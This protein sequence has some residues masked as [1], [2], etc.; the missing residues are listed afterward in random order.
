MTNINRGGLAGLGSLF[1]FLA[2][3]V[4]AADEPVT[5]LE[6]IRVSTTATEFL[7]IDNIH[8]VNTKR[9]I[10]SNGSGSLDQSLGRDYPVQVLTNGSPGTVTFF[11]G[12]GVRSE[13]TNVQTLGVSLNPAYGGGFDFSTM[14]LFMWSSYRYQV[15]QTSA[16]FDPRSSS[17]VVSLTPWTAEE[18]NKKPSDLS[19]QPFGM[20]SSLGQQQI[21]LRGTNASRTAA[22]AIGQSLGLSQ[23]QSGTLSFK[24]NLGVADSIRFH[25]IATDLLS[26]VPGTTVSPTPL[27][28]QRSSRLLPIINWDH[29][30]ELIIS[31]LTFYTDLTNLNYRSPEGGIETFDQARVY[32]ANYA[33]GFS[34]WKFGLLGK[35]LVYKTYIATPEEDLGQVQIIKTI[36]IG[37]KFLIEPLMRATTITGYGLLPEAAL[38]FRYELSQVFK[39]FSR[40]GVTRRFP[41]LSDRFYTLPNGQSQANAGLEPETDYSFTLGVDTDVAGRMNNLLQLTYQYSENTHQFL[42]I[43][44]GSLTYS[45]QN[46]GIGQM[47]S[48]FHIVRV[49]LMP[50]FEMTKT[51]SI[52]LSRL[53]LTRGKYNNLPWAKN[54]YVFRFHD[55]SDNEKW[56]FS[57]IHTWVSDSVT[58]SLGTSR[59]LASYQSGDVAFDYGLSWLRLGLKVENIVDTRY[60]IKANEPVPGRTYIASL[61][62]MF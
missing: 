32:G 19:V 37:E 48:L 9:P 59:S 7:Q 46:A 11:R 4:Y 29:E 27:T 23:G 36:P 33:L 47:V 22:V 61:S 10:Y 8:P 24:Q 21:S 35:R 3:L 25:L 51:F 31:K 49:D 20:V 42:P 5:L 41:T 2:T 12:F 1:L 54:V 56:S 45:T 16:S 62:A 57:I 30:T 58:S 13:D 43:S 26:K 44:S 15:G 53:D 6:P 34:G 14:P 38:G 17:G 50:W 55:P 28:T 52:N 60:E 18:I 40:S 39:F